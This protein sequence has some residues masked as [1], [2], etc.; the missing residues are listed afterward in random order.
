MKKTFI[1]LGFASILFLTLLLS[2]CSIIKPDTHFQPDQISVVTVDK[3]QYPIQSFMSVLDKTIKEINAD[4]TRNN[5]ILFVH[6]RGNH[7]AKAFKKKNRLL[8]NLESDYSSK[9]IMFHWPSWEGPFGVPEDKAR[10][11]AANLNRIFEDLK[12]YTFK[13]KEAVKN[14][15]FTLL[16]HSMGSIVLEEATKIANN[17]T[18][19]NLFDTIVV[20]ASASRAMDSAK[21]IDRINVSQDIYITINRKDPVLTGLEKKIKSKVIGKSIAEKNG[22]EFPLSQNAKYIDVTESSLGH[23][24]YLHKNLDGCPVVKSFFNDTLN[25]IPAELIEGDTVKKILYKRF[26]ILNRKK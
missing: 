16:C 14:I 26:Y 7:P 25:G 9:V 10:A 5:L 15:R 1:T 3:A 23:R 11:A 4:D 13:N 24:Y 21:W 19:T 2:G 18:K 8:S 12:S 17:S 6:G 22:V 20:T